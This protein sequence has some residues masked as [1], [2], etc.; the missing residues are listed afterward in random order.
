ME[1]TDPADLALVD[2]L[3]AGLP[4]VPR[5][6]RELGRPIGLG[7]EEVIARIRH[8]IEV[9]VIKRFGVVV[10]HHELGYNA[11]AMTVWQVPEEEIDRLGRRLGAV[12][13]I[14]LCYR[15]RP[16]PPRWPYNLYCMI[17]GRDRQ[18]VGEVLE[19]ITRE[20]GL[21]RFPRQVLFS[22]RRFRQQGARY[23]LCAGGQ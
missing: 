8:L 7:E 11:N 14:S 9:G 12:P 15:R 2:A 6:Y 3:C 23:R 1:L 20:C 19:R 22:G 10:R 4:L 18:W 16:A 5:P 21:D 13:E 17:H